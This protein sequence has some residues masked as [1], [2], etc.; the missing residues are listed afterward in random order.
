MTTL[1]GEP[2]VNIDPNPDRMVRVGQLEIDVAAMA[3]RLDG[4]RLHLP[5]REFQVLLLLADNAGRVLSPASI[6]SHVWEPGFEDT[7]GNLKIHINRLRNRMRAHVDQD[8]IRTVRGVGYC[9]E[10]P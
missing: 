2:V 6:G 7:H 4:T 1:R 3:V 8:Y 10:A 5:L 9:L